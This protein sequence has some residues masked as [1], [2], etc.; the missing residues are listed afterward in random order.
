MFLNENEVREII[1]RRLIVYEATRHTKVQELILFE[2]A[3]GGTLDTITTL[4][5]TISSLETPGTITKIL[6]YVV[7]IASSLLLVSGSYAILTAPLGHFAVYIGAIALLSG[8]LY[9]ARNYLQ[10]KIEA[11]NILS[12]PEVFFLPDRARNPVID[13]ANTLAGGISR[14]EIKMPELPANFNAE[15]GIT[16]DTKDLGKYKKAIQTAQ[17]DLEVQGNADNFL[18]IPITEFAVGTE[19]AVSAFVNSE[20]DTNDVAGEFVKALYNGNNV[21]DDSPDKALN[22]IFSNPG[23]TVYDLWKIDQAVGQIVHDRTEY[24]M[25]W[26]GEGYVSDHFDSTHADFVTESYNRRDVSNIIYLC[27][28]FNRVLNYKKDDVIGM[29]RN[30]FGLE[31]AFKRKILPFQRDIHSKLGPYL[32]GKDIAVISEHSDVADDAYTR[33]GEGFFDALSPSILELV[34]NSIKGFAIKIWEAIKYGLKT[35]F[36]WA[37]EKI[38][39]AYIWWTAAFA[40]GFSA[41]FSGLTAVYEYLKNKI[42]EF[43]KWVSGNESGGGSGGGSG[44]SNVSA[45]RSGSVTSGRSYSDVESMQKVMNNYLKKNNLS[46]SSTEEDG[47]WGSDTDRLWDVVVNHAFENHPVFSTDPDKDKYN[48]GHH[49]WGDMS[50]ALQ[51]D[52]GPSYTGYNNRPSGALALVLDMYNGNVEF[53]NG[54]ALPESIGPGDVLDDSEKGPGGEGET[55]T[56]A[57]VLDTAK[58]SGT[59]KSTK[60]GTGERGVKIRIETGKTGINTLED[61]GFDPGTT[62]AVSLKIIEGIRKQNFSGTDNEGII[63]R[64]SFNRR[65]KVRLVNFDTL[66]PDIRNPLKLFT[67][68][69][70][71][72]S[73]LTSFQPGMLNNIKGLLSAQ[74][75]TIDENE[76]NYKRKFYM[77]VTIPGGV[78]NV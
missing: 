52:N 74:G 12:D 35:S 73:E 60:T 57:G 42:V 33:I 30:K 25:D 29:I 63:I 70:Q 28:K 55:E 47:R 5:S 64:V 6:P 77:T 23:I 66:I 61:I 26:D 51:D 16:P 41:A 34:V 58:G 40:G 44:E 54:K 1:K 11:I 56:S 45:G 18:G 75:N 4:I 13:F 19:N 50:S 49:K 62:N 14:G 71:R 9:M 46:D 27:T 20:V 24:D 78:K 65:G 10:G 69:V 67:G 76:V 3:G 21:E 68:G 2:Q 22:A 7:D 31:D 72:L 32:M 37:K 8:G 59:P 36:N 53:G 38:N 17:D 15:Y 48:D 39:E 43:F